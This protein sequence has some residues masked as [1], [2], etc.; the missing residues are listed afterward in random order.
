MLDTFGDSVKEVR[1]RLLELGSYRKIFDERMA[2]RAKRRK[3]GKGCFPADSSV[4]RSL[5][6]FYQNGENF[7]VDSA[8]F[9]PFCKVEGGNSCMIIALNF[10][11]GVKF[12]EST[13]TFLPFCSNYDKRRRSVFKSTGQLENCA[14]NGLIDEHSTKVSRKTLICF[15]TCRK[16][17]PL[18]IL[19]RVRKFGTNKL[20]EGNWY[21]FYF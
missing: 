5:S 15:R 9:H 2:K 12:A 8:I 19:N 11:F 4:L 16:N 1:D 18:R 13:E 21:V 10:Y 6:L 14:F 20:S 7:T 17:Q 3:D